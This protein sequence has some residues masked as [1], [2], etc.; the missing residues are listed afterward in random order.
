[1]DWKE[2]NYCM[3]CS[4]T[5]IISTELFRHAFQSKEFLPQIITGFAATQ[6][7]MMTL[8]LPKYLIKK[9]N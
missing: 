8:L 3:T 4:F 9:F 2:I 5:I 1:M 6:Y 7:T